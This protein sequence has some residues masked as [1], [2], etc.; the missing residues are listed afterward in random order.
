MPSA[1]VYG[2][3]G[4]VGIRYVLVFVEAGASCAIG[5]TAEDWLKHLTLYLTYLLFQFLYFF[6]ILRGGRLLFLHLL[7]LFFECGDAGAML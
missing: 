1:S 7:Y 6:L 4:V 2:A 3:A 5:L